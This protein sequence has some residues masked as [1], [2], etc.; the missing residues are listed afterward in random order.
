[1]K[2]KKRK[3][4]EELTRC[5]SLA[6]RTATRTRNVYLSNLSDFV[7]VDDISKIVSHYCS[8]EQFF[9]KQRF[10]EAI[11]TWVMRTRG[12]NRYHWHIFDTDRVAAAL[13]SSQDRFVQDWLKEM[14]AIFKWPCV[15][16]GLSIYLSLNSDRCN[17]LL[18]WNNT[19]CICSKPLSFGYLKAAASRR[20]RRR[21]RLLYD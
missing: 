15:K 20:Y 8:S 2:S 1:M 12:G 14:Q 16:E 10:E 13:I 5:I 19:S 9:D 21:R 18:C 4:I 6:K 3:K 11:L 7:P 17:R